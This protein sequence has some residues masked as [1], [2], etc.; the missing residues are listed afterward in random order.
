[1]FPHNIILGLLVGGAV[2]QTTIEYEYLK[3]NISVLPYT[4]EQRIEVA[5]TMKTLLSV[6]QAY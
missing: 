2:A 4:A 5:T 6:F 3:S 1:M